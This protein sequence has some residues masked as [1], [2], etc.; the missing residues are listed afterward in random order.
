MSPKMENPDCSARITGSCG[1]TMEL[2]F[3]IEDNKV[4]E[5]HHW[6]DGCTSSRDCIESAAR[7]A[8][9]RSLHELKSLNMTHVIEQIGRL[10]ETH[11][12]CAQL[13]EITLHSAVDDYFERE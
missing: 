5:V 6:T 11:L 9:G 8:Q 12:H 13:A 4:A 2:R 7:L 3:K 1:D 10:P